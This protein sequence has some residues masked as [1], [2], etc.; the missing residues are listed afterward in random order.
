MPSII[1]FRILY[2]KRWKQK[3]AIPRSALEILKIIISLALWNFLT[4][5]IVTIFAAPL[6]IS[7]DLREIVLIIDTTCNVNAFSFTTTFRME[8]RLQYLPRRHFIRFVLHSYSKR[9]AE[10]ILYKFSNETNSFFVNIIYEKYL[11]KKLRCKRIDICTK[12]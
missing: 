11:K 12:I 5:Q 9:R 6:S 3:I 1:I 8:I 2:W 7:L 4:E 10:F